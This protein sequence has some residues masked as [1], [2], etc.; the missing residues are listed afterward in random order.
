MKIEVEFNKN[1]VASHGSIPLHELRSRVDS[2]MQKQHLINAGDGLYCSPGMPQDFAYC[3]NAILELKKA[4][5]FMPYISKWLWH[6]D[7]GCE[8]IAAYFQTK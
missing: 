3:G 5:W 4:D 7:K 8:D 2:I 6:T 1:K